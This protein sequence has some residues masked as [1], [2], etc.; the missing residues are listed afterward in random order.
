MEESAVSAVLM[1]DIQ[2]HWAFLQIAVFLMTLTLAIVGA[3][4]ATR[5]YAVLSDARILYW[6]SH[7][8]E[9]GMSQ[10]QSARRAT[11]DAINSAA[12]RKKVSTGR[13]KGV[14]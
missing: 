3:F 2:E 1:N 6:R 14:L 5:A 4:L 13:K 11:P 8:A 10:K 12:D 9:K 7:E